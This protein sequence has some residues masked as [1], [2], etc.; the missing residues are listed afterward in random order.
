MYK[1]KHIKS[2]WT[3]R[4]VTDRSL[5]F[6]LLSDATVPILFNFEWDGRTITSDKHSLNNTLCRTAS[7]KNAMPS[8][9]AEGFKNTSVPSIHHERLTRWQRHIPQ[10]VIR[11]QNHCGN[12]RRRSTTVHVRGLTVSCG[13][14][15]YISFAA[16]RVWAGGRVGHVN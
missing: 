1:D 8:S 12:L 15:L 9:R 5:C 16:A 11:Q 10:S 2:S 13:P 3:I 4:N 7:P 6:G 14:H